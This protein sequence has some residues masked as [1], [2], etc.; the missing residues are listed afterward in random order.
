MIIDDMSTIQVVLAAS[1]RGVRFSACTLVATQSLCNV[2]C[3]D[4]I[5]LF[6]YLS[7]FCTRL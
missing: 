3:N 1:A 4:D 5:L 6:S 7:I 2:M